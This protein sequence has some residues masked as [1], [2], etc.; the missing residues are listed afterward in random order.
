MKRFAAP[1]LLVLATTHFVGDD[2]R[3]QVRIDAFQF[4]DEALS[5]SASLSG[6]RLLV[7]H[8]LGAAAAGMAFVYEEGPDGAWQQVARLDVPGFFLV[9][10]AVA[11]D[12]ERALVSAP[13]SGND[14]SKPGPITVFDRDE[15]GQFVASGTLAPP[16]GFI[17]FGFDTRSIALSGDVAMA[18][19]KDHPSH[20]SGVVC[21]YERQPDGGWLQVDQLQG[22]HD[23]T[24]GDEFGHWIDLDGNRVVIGAFYSGD[25]FPRTGAATV[26][27]RGANGRW[28]MVADLR[29]QSSTDDSLYGQTVALDGDRVLVGAPALNEFAKHGG[30]VFLFERHADGSWQHTRTWSDATPEE[31]ERFGHSLMLTDRVA[32]VTAAP[33]NL[34]GGDPAPYANTIF[35]D[36]GGGQWHAHASFTPDRS[37]WSQLA[38]AEG[39]HLVYH[40]ST[41]N[42]FS[43]LSHVDLLDVSQFGEPLQTLPDP[44]S[45]SAGG[46]RHM[47][48]DAGPAFA[49]RVFLVLGTVSGTDPGIEMPGGL[50]LP[51]NPDFWF[52]M[53]LHNAGRFPVACG[54]GQLDANGRVDAT[55]ALPPGVGRGLAGLTVHHACVVFDAT[56]TVPE[57]VSNVVEF[58]FER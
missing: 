43:I 41:A 35:E 42:G 26:W 9:G 6:S 17:T 44:H 40:S 33:W 36:Q 30:G 34:D 52:W 8:P 45:L 2:A 25:A 53:G 37:P 47:R 32:V 3:A 19:A 46:D 54:L 49:D 58:Q 28:T 39:T 24:L 11:L 48:V 31:E 4:D 12:G 57:F 23:P 56:W 10:A 20:L 18:A 1:A 5:D 13:F 55:F 7:G 14:W 51:L 15:D 21:V 38:A 27:E 16:D 22:P 50:H 29:P